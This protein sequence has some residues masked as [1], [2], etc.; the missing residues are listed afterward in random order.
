MELLFHFSLQM[1]T[2]TNKR[3]DNENS[4]VNFRLYLNMLKNDTITWEVFFQI[5]KDMISLLDLIKSKKLIFDLIKELKEFKS[6]EAQYM[7]RYHDKQ[8][9]E[10]INKLELSNEMLKKENESLKETMQWGN[11]GQID[12]ATYNWHKRNDAFWKQLYEQIPHMKQFM[13]T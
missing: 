7:V 12:G 5:M 3:S 2:P 9:I 1:E 10:Q 11:K 8:K 6:R 13:P 4:D